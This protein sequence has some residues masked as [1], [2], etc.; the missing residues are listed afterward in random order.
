MASI[1]ILQPSYLPWVGYFEQIDK[2]DDFIYY[3][4]VQYT[5][6]DWRNRNRIKE[7]KGVM[8]LSVPVKFQAGD[9]IKDVLI[10]NSKP[11]I[12]KHL[13]A[14]KSNYSKSS[15][16]TDIF[17]L[18]ENVLNNRYD[19]LVELN[20]DLIQV[21]LDYLEITT[22]THLSS[23]L[24]VSGEKN[25]R[26]VKICKYY[27]AKEYYSGEA[28]KNYLDKVL[29]RKNGINVT[30]QSFNH[31]AYSQQFNNEFIPY[32][33]I[34]DLLFNEGKNSIKYIRSIYE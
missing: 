7:A 22:N 9:L 16:Y 33:S 11:W 13:N 12:R 3:D 31:R 6:N 34:V 32:L 28:A 14:L 30:F 15:Y 26:L 27:N 23:E 29:F 4:D 25:D 24:N 1:A 17:P 5:K 10:D 21:V 19:R 2:V 20:K 18:L 8:W